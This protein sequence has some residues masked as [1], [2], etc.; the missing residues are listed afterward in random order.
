MQ[1]V[2]MPSPRRINS[3][4]DL[5]Y[6]NHSFAVKG[7]GYCLIIRGFGAKEARPTPP[8]PS[9]KVFTD[10]SAPSPWQGYTQQL[11]SFTFSPVFRTWCGCGR[12]A[13]K[14][15]RESISLTHVGVT[16][17]GLHYFALWCPSYLAMFHLYALASF[18]VVPP[19]SAFF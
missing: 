12:T 13:K 2:M 1:A 7:S 14:K 10:S 11:R 17:Y 15:A 9:K 18:C 4:F 19:A 6:S 8:P 16:A 3:Y 5:L